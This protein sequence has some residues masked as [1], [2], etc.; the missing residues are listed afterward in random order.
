[1]VEEH[2]EKIENWYFHKQTAFP[3]FTNW[4]CIETLKSLTFLPFFFIIML[5]LLFFKI[6]VCCLNN[7]WG[8]DCEPCPGD[9]QRPCFG[10]G[11]CDVRNNKQTL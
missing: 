1:M 2:E 9:L 3:D 11:K 6:L 4:L 5:N 10:R 8:K 7:T